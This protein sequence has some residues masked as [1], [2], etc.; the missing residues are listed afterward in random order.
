M[1][2]SWLDMNGLVLIQLVV[3]KDARGSFRERFHAGKF[4]ELGLPIQFV[5]ENHAQ[6]RPG[7]L[8]GLHFQYAPAQGKLVGVLRGRIWDVVVDLR[9][10]SPTFGE[11]SATE[12]SDAN[13]QLL[14]IPAGFAHGYCVLG[15]EPADVVYSVDAF[16]NPDGEGGIQ[17][18]DP[19]LGIAW[20]IPNPIVS[21]R[22]QWL[23]RFAH[24]RSAPVMWQG[25]AMVRAR[26]NVN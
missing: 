17:W 9:S 3:H 12:L 8:R 26:N 2:A 22:D 20:P 15:D 6:S 23:S 4:Q 1:K 13:G 19:D 10:D 14:W 25:V 11:H 5:Q 21:K 24:Y 18:N 7:V 16:Y